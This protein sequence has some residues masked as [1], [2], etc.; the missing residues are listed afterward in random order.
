MCIDSITLDS[1]KRKVMDISYPIVFANAAIIIPF[2]QETSK[3]IDTSAFNS[4][5]TIL[6]SMK[7][8]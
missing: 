7:E 1:P 5:V 2:P 6:L 8:L 4:Q 3:W